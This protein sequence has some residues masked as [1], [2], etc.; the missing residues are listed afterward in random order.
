MS[1]MSH[2]T[3][4]ECGG[5]SDTPKTCEDSDCIRNGQDMTECECTDGEH[6]AD[7]EDVDY[8]R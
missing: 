1:N 7:Y 8:A 5:E 6:G 2:Y 4:T 3:C